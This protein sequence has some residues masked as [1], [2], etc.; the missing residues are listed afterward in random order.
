M[1]KKNGL[2]IVL[3][4]MVIL[5]I[6]VIVYVIINKNNTT[7]TEIIGFKKNTTS[8]HVINRKKHLEE[9]N[10][11]D[12]DVYQK[13]II[14]N[15]LTDFSYN[16]GN[17]V[18]NINENNE[19]VIND[20]IVFNDL[21]FK[22]L[23]DKIIFNGDKEYLFLISNDNKLYN[24]SL[25]EI[26]IDNNIFPLTELVTEGNVLNFV[27]INFDSDS[28][29]T[30]N[31]IFILLDNG[32]IYEAFSGLRYNSKIKLLF[33]N[34]LVYQDKTIS[35]VSGYIF[36]DENNN[37]YK[38]KY[39]FMTKENNDDVILIITEDNKMF[40]GYVKEQLFNY[41]V[42]KMVVKDILYDN[43][44]YM[45]KGLLKV[46]YEDDSVEEYEAICSKNYCVN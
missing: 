18:I 10:I 25:T 23:Y 21:K 35:N 20:K 11:I 33:D 46:Y 12:K 5:L 37:E 15:I 32:K 45:S 40:F 42:K 13:N 14:T 38:I 26:N 6:F 22:T 29:K 39:A 8:L 7:D 1:K 27:D 16:N 43:N 44:N 4:A 2:L 34:I 24:L 41:Y 30:N 36:K 31:L 28:D 3:I 9:E 17:V 19:L